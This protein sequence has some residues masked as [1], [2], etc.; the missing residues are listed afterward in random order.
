M[1]TTVTTSSV[2]ASRLKLIAVLRA[3]RP[4]QWVK[5]SV[6]FI[7]LVF[8]VR[9][10]EPNEVLRALLTFVAFCA[11]SSSVYLANDVVDVERDR[12]HPFKRQRPIALG[13]LTTREAL[14]AAAGLAVAAFV[15]AFLVRPAVAI[16]ALVYATLNFAYTL[17]LKR[18]V[19]LDIFAIASGFVIRVFAGTAAIAVQISPWLFVETLLLALF[20]ALVRRRAEMLSLG[21]LGANHRTVLADYNLGFI[22]QLLTMTGTGVLI[23]YSLYTFNS[24]HS[25]RLMLTIPVV[26]FALFRYLYLIHQKGMGE[27]PEQ[28]V[29]TDRTLLATVC[30][31]TVMVLI[32]LGA[33]R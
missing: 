15:L 11:L 26:L 1:E 10:V 14:L 16:F 2:A 28:V 32:T 29:F 21:Q 8:S 22:D 24:T 6:V 13:Q 3:M 9:F 27:D 33:S 7:G 25:S 5:N 23:S 20:L 12:L 31:Y 18:V 17:S 4:R 30:I 19:L